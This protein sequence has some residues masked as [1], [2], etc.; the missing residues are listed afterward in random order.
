MIVYTVHA[1]R[2][3]D[4]ECH[5]YPIGVYISRELALNAAKSVEINR[6]GKYTCEVIEWEVVESDRLPQRKTIKHLPQAERKK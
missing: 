3:G 1:Y 5:S 6:S 2:W 4:R